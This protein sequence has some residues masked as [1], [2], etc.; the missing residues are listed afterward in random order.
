MSDGKIVP[1]IPDD[2]ITATAIAKALGPGHS[3]M[4]NPVEPCPTT[5]NTKL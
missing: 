4:L 2:A 1:R 5:Q 3:G